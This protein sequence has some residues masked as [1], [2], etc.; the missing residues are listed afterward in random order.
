[1]LLCHFQGITSPSTQL[2]RFKSFS[3][4]SLTLQSYPW[5]ICSTHSSPGSIFTRQS[6]AT[7]HQLDCPG[8][9]YCAAHFCGPSI[10][11]MAVTV[12]LLKSVVSLPPT[13]WCPS[14]VARSQAIMKMVLEASTTYLTSLPSFLTSCLPLH[15]W[16]MLG[17][18]SLGSSHELLV[19]VAKPPF[20]LHLGLCSK[21][22]SQL[23]WPSASRVDILQG[24][25]CLLYS[26]P[27]PST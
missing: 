22:F 1:M 3:K 6:P 21:H 17:D 8:R 10:L 26:L 19:G 23:L 20:S 27:N 11:H 4:S 16:I 13:Y 7:S 5:T 15:S 9:H 24:E 14:Y 12:L 25:Y 18:A 2:L